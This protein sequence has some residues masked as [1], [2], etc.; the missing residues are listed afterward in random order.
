VSCMFI[1]LSQHMLLES[2]VEE[3]EVMSHIGL[4]CIWSD[5]KST[6]NISREEFKAR[7]N[8]EDRGC[9]WEGTIKKRNLTETEVV[10]LCVVF[11]WFGVETG[12]DLVP[13]VNSRLKDRLQPSGR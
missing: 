7:K 13:R 11:V 3:G 8:L 2:S 9:G 12:R 6:Q 10:R 4:R 5:K 1:A